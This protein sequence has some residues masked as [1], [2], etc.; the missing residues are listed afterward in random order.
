MQA[1]TSVEPGGLEP[2]T[3]WVRFHSRGLSSNAIGCGVRLERGFLAKS[4]LLF[5]A[6]LR[7]RYLT[8]T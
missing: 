8:K 6:A 7:A 3:S 1:F 4:L 5:V 2:A